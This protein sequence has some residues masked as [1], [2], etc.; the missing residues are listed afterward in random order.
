MAGVIAGAEPRAIQAQEALEAQGEIRSRMLTEQARKR[1]ET[2]V[3]AEKKRKEEER[4]AKEHAKLIEDL[5][6]QGLAGQE[7]SERQLEQ[8]RHEDE[9]KAKHEQNLRR[10]RQEKAQRDAEHQRR[11][12]IRQAEKDTNQML[13]D[14]AAIW[15]YNQKMFAGTLTERDVMR[16]QMRITKEQYQQMYS[17]ALQS[18]TPSG[19]PQ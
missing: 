2:Q 3:A 19:L 1:K 16:M 11:A 6:N 9:R 18:P 10:R 14:S 12:Q 17:R 8:G 13:D 4:K 7:R 15:D 5:N